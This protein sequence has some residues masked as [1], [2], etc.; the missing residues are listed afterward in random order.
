[1][2]WVREKVDLDNKLLHFFTLSKGMKLWVLENDWQVW[3]LA[4]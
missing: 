2:Y 1:M 4:S 3:Y